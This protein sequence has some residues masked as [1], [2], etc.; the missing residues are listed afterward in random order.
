[1]TSPWFN[2]ITEVENRWV[3]TEHLRKGTPCVDDRS[4]N[5]ESQ[6][7]KAGKDSV[8]HSAPF[9]KFYLINGVTLTSKTSARW[10]IKNF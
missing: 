2:L 10:E 9:M 3:L 8:E 5:F 7:C 4:L 1:M 6:H